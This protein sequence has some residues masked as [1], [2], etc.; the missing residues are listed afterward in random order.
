MQKTRPI[1]EGGVLAALLAIGHLACGASAETG[2]V[3]ST[4]CTTSFTAC[5][6]D[7]TGTWN[8]AGVCLDGDLAAALNAERSSACAAQTTGADVRVTGSVMYTAAAAGAD[9]VVI[10][11]GTTEERST[12]SV[13]P[14]CAMDT[15]GVTTLDANGCTQ[16]QTMLVNNDPAKKVTCGLSGVNCGCRVTIVRARNV[17]NLVTMTGSN[18]VESDDA[19]YDVCVTGNAMV[20][21]QTR[22]GNVG[23][24]TR[25]EKR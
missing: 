4:L 11:K 2:P 9:P 5:G 15:Y 1:R 10:Y 14:A 12:E 17:Q 22:A 16:I 21:R 18:I 20:Q 7:P 13:S 19:T 24:I 3:T 6:G 23:A 25:M 8:V